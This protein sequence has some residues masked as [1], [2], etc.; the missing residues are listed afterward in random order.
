LQNE[1]KSTL[2]VNILTFK[3]LKKFKKNNFNKKMSNKELEKNILFN[4]YRWIIEIYL[5]P[6]DGL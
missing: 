3:T 4:A 2:N 6:I 5:M 1:K